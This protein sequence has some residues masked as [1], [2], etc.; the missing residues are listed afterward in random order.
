MLGRKPSCR[1]QRAFST[2]AAFAV[3][4]LL[5]PPPAYGWGPV[6]HH[7]VCDA[8]IRNLPDEMRPFFTHHRDYIVEHSTDPDEWAKQDEAEGPRHYINLDLFDKYPFSKIP[9]SYEEAVKKFG[10]EKVDKEGTLPWVIEEYQKKLTEAFKSRR[11]EEVILHASTISHYVA[12][13]HQPFHTTKNYKGQLTGNLM[14]PDDRDNRHVHIRFEYML[15]EHFKDEFRAGTLKRT[16][17]ARPVANVQSYIWRFLVRSY[18]YVDPLIKADLEITQRHAVFDRKYYQLLKQKT[19]KIAIRQL[20][21]SSSALASL[22]YTAWVAAGRP[23]LPAYEPSASLRSS[24]GMLM[25]ATM[26]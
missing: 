21:E 12:D 16:R 3:L 24:R 1:P 9:R 18:R 6:G 22:W 20:A 10:K 11:W 14:A 23:R 26:S 17:R 13:A 19:A 8:A 7:I 25:S 15:L 4:L 2:V 5:V